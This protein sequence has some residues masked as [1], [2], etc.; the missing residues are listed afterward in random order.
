MARTFRDVIVPLTESL[1]RAA[2]MLLVLDSYDFYSLPMAR[3]ACCECL[4]ASVRLPILSHFRRDVVCNAS[5][6][7]GLRL[8]QLRLGRNSECFVDWP[9]DAKIGLFFC[10]DLCLLD[11]CVLCFFWYSSWVS[12]DLE[13]WRLHGVKVLLGIIYFA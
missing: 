5:K 6:Q 11:P 1:P 12:C 8:K 3:I 9:V 10:F 13:Y 7:L 4:V 2:G